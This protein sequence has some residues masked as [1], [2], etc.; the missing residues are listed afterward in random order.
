MILVVIAFKHILDTNVIDGLLQVASYTYGPL[1][2]LFSFGIFTKYQVKDRYVWLVAVIS[3]L[4]I[5][6]LARIPAETL[7]GYA[8]GYE[9]LPING[10]FTFVGL[11]AIRVKPIKKAV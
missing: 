4:L 8:F 9:L 2:G 3:V 10:I 6:G 1:L 5:F 11:W 7:G